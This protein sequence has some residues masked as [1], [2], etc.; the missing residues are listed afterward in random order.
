M[1]LFKSTEE[2]C[3]KVACYSGYEQIERKLTKTWTRS[4]D[5][6]KLFGMVKLFQ[7]NAQKP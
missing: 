1:L 2:N 3:L 5:L 4:V 7:Y 6:S